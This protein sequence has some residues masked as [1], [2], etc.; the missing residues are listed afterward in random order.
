MKRIKMFLLLLVIFLVTG[1]SVEYNLTINKDLS[2]NEKVIASDN[3]IRLKIN[4]NLN[5]KDAVNY[6][7]K[8]FD[9]EGLQTQ[10]STI[11]DS[12]NTISTVTGKHKSLENYVNNFT[13]DVFRYIDYQEDGDI[14]TLTMNQSEKVGRDRS[15]TLLYNN[16]KV[17]IDL[18]FKVK[19]H[20]ADEVRYSKYTWNIDEN[21]GLKTIRISF[22]KN[23]LRDE[24]KI[25]IGG[26]TFNIKYQYIALF[27]IC[28]IL[29]IIFIVVLINNKKNNRI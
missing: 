10:I 23:A 25:T 1:C 28:L 16:I 18:P 26:K 19:E 15:N 29:G 20:N 17:V 14:I 12:G 4:T 22:D 21:E 6:L 9:R 3:T 7:Y 11:T 24:Q 13:S 27:I 5:E 2:V 8:M